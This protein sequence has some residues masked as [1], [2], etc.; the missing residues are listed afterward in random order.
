MKDAAAKFFQLPLEEK[1]KVAMT[2]DAIQ[3]YG[4][5]YTISEDQILD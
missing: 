3:G 4:H 1:D 2:S 5:V